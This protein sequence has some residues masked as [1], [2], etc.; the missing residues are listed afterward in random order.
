VDLNPPLVVT[1]G[2]TQDVSILLDPA[3]LFRQGGNVVDLSAQ[4]GR[5]LR[6]E[7]EV[8]N[9]FSGRSGSN[10]GRG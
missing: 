9:G 8:E 3:A 4:N 7:L 1:E 6:M 5:L 10:S 2:S